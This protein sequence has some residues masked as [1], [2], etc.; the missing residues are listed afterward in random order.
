MT[1]LHIVPNVKFVCTVD[2]FNNW[3]AEEREE[4][5]VDF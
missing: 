2:D 4:E 3:L 1:L 5:K